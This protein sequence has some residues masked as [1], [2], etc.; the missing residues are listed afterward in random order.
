[1]PRSRAGLLIIIISD[2]TAGTMRLD[3]PGGQAPIN[4]MIQ[5]RL[6]L[7][8]T[9]L[10]AES[11]VRRLGVMAA[12]LPGMRRDLLTCMV[13]LAW[14]EVVSRAALVAFIAILRQQHRDRFCRC[15]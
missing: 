7:R 8:D 14:G 12:A 6:G 13:M 11:T 4:A 1:M 10:H 3:L 9:V 2:N 15:R 5:I